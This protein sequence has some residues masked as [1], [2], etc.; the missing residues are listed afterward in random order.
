MLGFEGSETWGK[1]KGRSKIFSK[2]VSAKVK[3]QSRR[4]FE[5]KSGKCTFLT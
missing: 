1:K 3:S 2:R 4:L 5:I